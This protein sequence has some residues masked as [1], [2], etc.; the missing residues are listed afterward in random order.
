MFRFLIT[1]CGFVLDRSGGDVLVS[2]NWVLGD[3]PWVVVNLVGEG[4]ERSLKKLAKE[5]GIAM[6]PLAD[7]SVHGILGR[8]AEVLRAWCTAAGVQ[9]A[10]AS[11]ARGST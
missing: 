9:S 6:P 5:H 10:P 1:D 8:D 7:A 3:E 2:V 11:P 4:R